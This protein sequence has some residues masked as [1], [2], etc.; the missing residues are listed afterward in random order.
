M[1]TRFHR[2][3]YKEMQ[4]QMRACALPCLLALSAERAGYGSVPVAVSIPVTG[5]NTFLCSQEPGF[6]GDMAGLGLGSERNE[7][8]LEHPGSSKELVK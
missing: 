7:L 4:V 3:T 8:I 2:W 6:P 1:K 5:L